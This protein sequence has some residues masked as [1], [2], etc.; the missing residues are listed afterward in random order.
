M[1]FSFRSKTTAVTRASRSERK[2]TPARDASWGVFDRAAA[3]APPA[4]QE[5]EE[6]VARERRVLREQPRRRRARR[7][8]ELAELVR[9]GERLEPPIQ[10][11]RHLGQVLAD[12]EDVHC[13]AG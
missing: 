7:G 10:L 6:Q 5:D 9:I 12:F 2:R 4:E 13:L 11:V 3:G 8:D 1:V